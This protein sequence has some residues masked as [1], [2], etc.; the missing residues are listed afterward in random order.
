MFWLKKIKPES[1]QVWLL[2]AFC[3]LA[4]L[5]FNP[6]FAASGGLDSLDKAT[7]ALKDILSWL[8]GFVVVASILYIVYLVVMAIAEKKAWSDV[9][10]GLVYCAIAGGVVMGG[11]WATTLFT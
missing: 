3:L 2:L 11:E 5:A 7:N 4:L 1:G 9:T 6:A 10:M 8:K